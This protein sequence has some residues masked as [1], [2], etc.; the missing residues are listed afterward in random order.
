MKFRTVR[1]VFAS[2]LPCF[3]VVALGALTATADPVER[4]GE[5]A[6]HQERNQAKNERKT[7][8]PVSE[9]N[10]PAFADKPVKKATAVK[11]ASVSSSDSHSKAKDKKKAKQQQAAKAKAEAET[12][13]TTTVEYRPRYYYVEDRVGSDAPHQERASDPSK[14]GARLFILER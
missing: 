8:L 1:S 7:A 11:T 12:T 4:V 10:V 2:L 9:L 6:P 3:G 14:R 5:D 13:V